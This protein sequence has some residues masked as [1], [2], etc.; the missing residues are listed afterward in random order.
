M[1]EEDVYDKLRQGIQNLD[2]DLVR[3]SAEAA[4]KLGVSGEAISALTD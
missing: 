3:A 1:P 4:V 2:P